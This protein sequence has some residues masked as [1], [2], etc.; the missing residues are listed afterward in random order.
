M[1]IVVIVVFIYILN[2]STDVFVGI[3]EKLAGE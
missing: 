2:G 3:N 1:I